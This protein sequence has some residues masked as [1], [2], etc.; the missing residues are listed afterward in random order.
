MLS[1]DDLVSNTSTT[2][3][4]STFYSLFLFFFLSSLSRPSTP[5]HKKNQPL[6]RLCFSPNS[7]ASSC[8]SFY[9]CYRWHPTEWRRR[10]IFSN[11]VDSTEHPLDLHCPRYPVSVREVRHRV[12]RWGSIFLHFQI[13]FGF[14]PPFF[15]S[16][17][18]YWFGNWDCVIFVCL[19]SFRCITKPETGVWRSSQWAHPR[20]LLRLSPISN[21]M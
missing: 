18:I 2:S 5:N 8:F 1:I 19:L 9:C 14:H 6:P 16:F 13:G 21:R 11:K 12:R 20:R 4:T 3:E 10:R 17:S 15:S 7:I